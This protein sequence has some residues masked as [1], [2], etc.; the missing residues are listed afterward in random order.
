IRGTSLRTDEAA[1]AR[2]RQHLSEHRLTSR[3][4]K[5]PTEKVSG[6]ARGGLASRGTIEPKF[7]GFLHALRRLVRHGN[8]APFA[9]GGVASVERVHYD[10]AIFSGGLRRFFAA[11]AAREMGE[12]LRR[13]V[14]PQFFEYGIGPA[15]CGGGFFY[16]VAVAVF[17]E[18]GQCIAHVQIGVGYAGFSEDFDAV[19]HAA[20]A[21]PTVFDEADGAVGKF[22]DAERLIFGFGFVAVNIG[23]HLAVDGFDWGASEK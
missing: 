14:I 7:D 6:L 1:S 17:A 15:L 20:A 21:R 18:G 4:E 12:L 8:L 2:A 11:G 13:A 3:F 19:V 9:S 5:Q 23:A 16:G 10:Q 22:Q